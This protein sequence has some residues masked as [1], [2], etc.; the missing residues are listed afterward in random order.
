MGA[1][2]AKRFITVGSKLC[3]VLGGCLRGLSELKL[4]CGE[5]PPWGHTKTAGEADQIDI[6][7]ASVTKDCTDGHLKISNNAAE[8]AIRPLALGRKNWLFAGSDA[9]CPLPRL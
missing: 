8:N 5:G 2:C 6:S 4:L 7:S 3:W 9:D 1:Q